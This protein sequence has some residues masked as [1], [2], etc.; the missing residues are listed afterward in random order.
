MQA[1]AV[2]IGQ[3][4]VVITGKPGSGKSSL[5]FA[6]IDRG[7]T[8]IGD[9]GVALRLEADALLASP[10]PNIEGLLE[11][12]GVGLLTF[13]V[14]QAPVSLLVELGTEGERHPE[15][16]P[17]R[18]MLGVAIPVMQLGQTDWTSALRIEQ[19]LAMHGLA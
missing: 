8:L 1:S 9:D 6:L 19:A 13:P 16:L 12:R 15:T 18:E 17:R 4:A 5:A 2:A 11:L 14:T 3:R 7:A 10:P